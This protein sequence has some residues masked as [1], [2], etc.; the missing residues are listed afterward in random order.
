M[1]KESVTDQSARCKVT[2]RVKFL[3]IPI[4]PVQGANAGGGMS[5]GGGAVPRCGTGS[6]PRLLYVTPSASSGNRCARRRKRT[7]A[8]QRLQRG[9]V[10]TKTDHDHAHVHRDRSAAKSQP[11]P[12]TTTLTFTTTSTTTATFTRTKN[13]VA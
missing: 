12:I 8:A 2:A 6:A 4:A 5:T 1:D 3:D 7:L 11:K 10:A 13:T 9:K